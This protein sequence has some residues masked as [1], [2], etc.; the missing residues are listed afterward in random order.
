MKRKN[1]ELLIELAFGDLDA[2]EAERLRSELANDP[3]QQATL[4]SYE[5]LRAS[6]GG[7]RDV[8]EMQLSRERLRDAIL[9]GGLRETRRH[10]R[11]AWL[12]A[13]VAIAA[14]AFAFTMVF[15]QPSMPLPSGVALATNAAEEPFASMDPTLDRNSGSVAGLFGNEELKPLAFSE[16]T[17]PAVEKPKITAPAEK[18][19]R[20][21]R[22]EPKTQV[23]PA[24]VVTEPGP[25]AATL[26]SASTPPA[27]DAGVMTAGVAEE[28]SEIIVLTAETDID[29][30]ARR[31]TSM[32]SSS[33]VVIGG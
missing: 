3:T 31:A 26:A 17:E 16:R 22:A 18:R 6:I 21:A 4:R 30:G 32:E 27:T 14:V 25:A 13:P 24:P 33:N 5:E 12:G 28:S 10:D 29:T 1:E 11:W 8:P 7:L 23:K 2:A 15:R 19:V 20:V 9:A